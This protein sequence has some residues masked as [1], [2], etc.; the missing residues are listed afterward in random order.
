MPSATN[1]IA[2]LGVALLA[3]GGVVVYS[4][5]RN[6]TVADTLRSLIKGQAVT[7]SS[8]GSLAA[9]EA[10]VTG[11]LQSTGVN[12]GGSS[13]VSAARKY[14]GVP[15]SWA[16]SLPSGMDCSGLVNLAAGHDLGWPIPG[17]PD[18]KYSG[19]GPIVQ[20][21]FIW[22]GLTTIPASQAA[23]GDLVIWGPNAHMGIVVAAGR[24]IDAPTI[25]DVVKEQSIWTVPAP[26][27]RRYAAAAKPIPHVPV[28]G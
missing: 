26:T 10:S 7:G 24:M 18:G 9:S 21:W 5:V 28:G 17:H 13:L 1:G 3:A 6:A 8:T 11:Q 23:A 19:H 16:A 14:L 22:S 25:G 27:Y 12:A 15:Y 2:G 4:A 20:D